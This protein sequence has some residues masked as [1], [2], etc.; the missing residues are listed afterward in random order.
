[1]QRTHMTSCCRK[2]VFS[3]VSPAHPFRFRNH[4]AV[5]LQTKGGPYMVSRLPVAGFAVVEA[6]TMAEAVKLVS[7]TPCAVAHGVVEVWLLEQRK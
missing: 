6:A 1:M 5:T 4:D 7:Q 3:W 2:A